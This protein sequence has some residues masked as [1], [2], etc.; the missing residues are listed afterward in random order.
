MRNSK[1]GK[2]LQ[3]LL[4]AL[5]QEV[6]GAVEAVVN[7]LGR[8]VEDRGSFGGGEVLPFTENDDFPHVGRQLFNCGTDGGG[9]FGGQ[10]G[11]VGWRVGRRKDVAYAL[12]SI[13]AFGIEGDAG[14]AAEPA[15]VVAGE[16]GG[17]RIKP[18]GEPGA[19]FEAGAMIIDPHECLL[20][21]V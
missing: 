11:A 21:Q 20:R 14:V 2:I 16:V 15:A 9:P 1:A 7:S 6:A 3:P 4:E 18:S 13:F 10:G 19:V 17:D 5:A 12:A 8:G